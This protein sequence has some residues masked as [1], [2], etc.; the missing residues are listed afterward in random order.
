MQ[1]GVGGL[2]L[3]TRVGVDVDGG[4]RAGG[5]GE[6]EEVLNGG[7][8]SVGGTGSDTWGSR[9]TGGVPGGTGEGVGEGVDG[10]PGAR[11]CH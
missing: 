2:D 1:R 9:H 11:R 3:P 5:E 4:M 6:E 10:L 8:G 7:G